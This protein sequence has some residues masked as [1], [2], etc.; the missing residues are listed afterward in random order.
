[1]DTKIKKWGNSHAVRLPLAILQDAAMKE[2]DQVEIRAYK[3]C[4]TI[5]LAMRKHRTL[6]ERMADY[7]GSYITEEWETGTAQGGEEW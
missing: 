5:R 4:I 7:K 3:G 1:M 2:N 6:E